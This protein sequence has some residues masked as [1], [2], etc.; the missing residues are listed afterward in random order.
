MLAGDCNH[1]FAFGVSGLDISQSIRRPGKSKHLVHDGPDRTGIDQFG[2]L[3]QLR[4]V[5]VHERERIADPTLLVSAEA[6]KGDRANQ[7][8]STTTF[9]WALPVSR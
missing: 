6:E 8:I 1:D 9:P 4:A 7:V 2:V 5:G 3:G